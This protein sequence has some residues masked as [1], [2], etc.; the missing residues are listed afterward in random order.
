MSFD[1]DSFDYS[2]DDSY[3]HWDFDFDDFMQLL[4][5]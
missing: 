3:E 2:F 4:N 5:D 1:D